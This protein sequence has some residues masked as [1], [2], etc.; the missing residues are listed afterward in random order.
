MT[1]P[2]VRYFTPK[3][4]LL[5]PG[6]N[7][8]LTAQEDNWDRLDQAFS[9]VI[10]VQPG[11]IPDTSILYDGALVAESL[12]GKVWR[13]EKQLDGNYAQKWIK[14]PWLLSAK[15]TGATFADGI[16]DHEWGLD[17]VDAAQCVNANI[18]DIVDTRINIPLDGIYAIK[19]RIGWSNGTLLRS[20]KLVI[21]SVF[22][23]S[24][25]EVIVES[26]A[27]FPYPQTNFFTTRFL[28]KNDKLA[29]GMWQNSTFTGVAYDMRMEVAM[30]RP[31]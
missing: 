2:L 15:R 30:V 28:K 7:D 1:E 27:Y 21:N 11:T 18:N 23:T 31:T 8:G 17:N 3:L 20:M 22:D 19:M 16:A 5:V 14:Y 9:G 4:G 10:W 13:A 24:N 26:Q 29:M 12:S 25:T 6:V